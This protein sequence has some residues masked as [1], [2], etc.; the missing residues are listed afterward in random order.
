MLFFMDWTTF[1]VAAVTA[2]STL[3]G[4]GLG[5]LAARLQANV[6]KHQADAE[7][8]RQREEREH[9]ALQAKAQAYNELLNSIDALVTFRYY[10]SDLREEDIT[11][12]HDSF[13]QRANTVTLFG[14]QRVREART[15]L[16]LSLLV[17]WGGYRV[18][19]LPTPAERLKEAWSA[20]ITDKER[21]G[22]ISELINA[23]RAD[24]HGEHSRRDEIATDPIPGPEVDN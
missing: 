20:W 10:R 4:S 7:T 18:S 23:M 19:T 8:A 15:G 11:A 17:L 5:Y 21:T 6:G 14:S 22:S 1:S 3:A 24:I 13:A 12:W 2:A 16:A 9:E